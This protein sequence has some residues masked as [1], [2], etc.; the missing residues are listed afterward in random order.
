M[1]ACVNV[2]GH[3]LTGSCWVILQPAR[4]I[5]HLSPLSFVLIH[6]SHSL[7]LSYLL[8]HCWVKKNVGSSTAFQHCV[9]FL[10]WV[11]PMCLLT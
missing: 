7:F 8:F 5:F 6:L 10:Y 4:L 2:G 9:F 1:K 11:Q 3:D